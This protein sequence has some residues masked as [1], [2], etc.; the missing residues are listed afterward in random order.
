MAQV[1]LNG[2]I[3]I[4]STHSPFDTTTPRNWLQRRYENYAA[5]TVQLADEILV[6]GE[7]HAELPPA[8]HDVQEL[9]VLP[10]GGGHGKLRPLADETA[11]A[12]AVRGGGGLVAADAG[13]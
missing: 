6:G 4:K 3:K 8:R 12:R 7:G 10:T 1:H 5:S 13:A 11:Y 2:S 9:N